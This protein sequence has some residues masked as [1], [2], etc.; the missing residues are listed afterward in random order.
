[1]KNT[2][3]GQ[4]RRDWTDTS[5]H[6]RCA[7]CVYI[8]TG[9]LP[10]VEEFKYLDESTDWSSSVRDL[11]WSVM[12][13][14]AESK[15]KTL[16][17]GLSML[18]PSPTIHDAWI[19]T[20]WTRSFIWVAGIELG[21]RGRSSVIWRS[22]CSSSSNGASGG[23]LDM[24]LGCFLNAFLWSCSRHI[25]LARP[26]IRWRDCISSLAWRMWLVYSPVH[27][28]CKL[29]LPIYLFCFFIKVLN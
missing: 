17:T 28:R 5:P 23:G 18:K 26:R 20:E 12:V 3:G 21:E 15:S 7:F 29:L 24:W 9:S 25:P 16:S 19:V 4:T 2:S 10:Q 1:M 22:R 8:G 27:V 14:K 13:M 6:K 11:L